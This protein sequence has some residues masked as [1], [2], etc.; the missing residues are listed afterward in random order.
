GTE[1]NKFLAEH[2]R[3]LSGPVLCI[4]EGEGRNGVFLA[5]LG[6]EVLAVDSSAVGL[7]KARALAESRGVSIVTEVADLAD[8]IPS[9]DSYGAVVSIFAHLPSKIRQRLYPLLEQ[10]LT[11]GGLLLL[12][13]YNEAQINRDTGGPKDPDM[14][15]SEAKI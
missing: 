5:S 10:C 11:P 7:E 15:M 8:Y 13:A 12:E 6:L 1:P 14:L 3:E 9:P 2:A 4:A